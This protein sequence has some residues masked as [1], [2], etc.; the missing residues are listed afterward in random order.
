MTGNEAGRPS[1]RPARVLVVEDHP[2]LA[3]S[4]RICLDGA[5][6]TTTVAPVDGPEAVL[7]AASEAQPD[8]VLLDVDLG[9]GIGDGVVLVEPL[10]A[11]G[12]TVVVV[13]GTTEPARVG[14]FVERGAAG[15]VHKGRSLDELQAAV[16]RALDGRPLLS[17]AERRALR[18]DLEAARRRLAPFD[19]LSPREADV[20][21][22]LMDGRS[23]AE[24]AASAYVSEGTVRSQIRSILVK[25]G[26]NSQLQAVGAARRAGWPWR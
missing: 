2:L 18:Q 4:L 6:H 5:G 16:V 23:V 21:V 19:R 20:L 10:A 3:E 24:I 17:D 26:V 9:E 7:A 8:V 15:F 1:A 22:R 13:S 14:A 25:L 11:M 12:A